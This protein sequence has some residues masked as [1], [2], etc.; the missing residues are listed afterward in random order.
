MQA[1][2]PEARWR[3]DREKP[4]AVFLAAVVSARGARCRSHGGRLLLL[5]G[6]GTAPRSS[7]TASQ[8]HC[9]RSGTQTQVASAWQAVAITPTVQTRADPPGTPYRGAPAHILPTVPAGI[10]DE[11][12]GSHGL[13]RVQGPIPAAL[14]AKCRR[15]RT[16]RRQHTTASAREAMAMRAARCPRHRR[17]VTQ[18]A[19]LAGRRACARYYRGIRTESDFLDVRFVE[20]LLSLH[21]DE[22]QGHRRPGASPATCWRFR[23]AGLVRVRLVTAPVHATSQICLHRSMLT[24]RARQEGS[25]G[26]PGWREGKRLFLT[27]LACG[28]ATRRDADAKAAAP[29][30]PDPRRAR[31][32]ICPAVR[33]RSLA[34]SCSRVWPAAARPGPSASKWAGVRPDAGQR[35]RGM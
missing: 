4:S 24:V 23:G 6:L 8:L 34:R 18:S 13:E 1:S 29:P 7:S 25:R 35:R 11:I 26:E 19:A 5:L 33:V 9:C 2:C 14:C 27:N 22:I 32:R 3:G 21:H 12:L 20:K 15:S 31:S 16:A 17:A 10:V 30:C 28:G